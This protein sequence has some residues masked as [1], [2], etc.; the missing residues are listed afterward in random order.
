MGPKPRAYLVDD[1]PAV[2]E[3]LASLIGVLGF[4]VDSF[5]SAEE[6]L[7]AYRP[8]GPECLI[9]DVRLPGMSGLDL[10]RELGRRGSPLSIVFVTGHGD[11][12]VAAEAMKLGAVGFLEKPFQTQALL[13]SIH[14]ALAAADDG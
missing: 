4:E 5:A 7:E 12:S 13:D 8:G 9:L 2:V 10:Q 14:R 6:F 1:D 11:S 3:A